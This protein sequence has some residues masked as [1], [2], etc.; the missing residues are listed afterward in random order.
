MF[1]DE[2]DGHHHHRHA[3]LAGAFQLLLGGRADPF[4]RADAALV[5]H[6]PVHIGDAERA[7]HGP[8]RLLHMLGIGIALVHHP[9]RQAM[10][11]KQD[12]RRPLFRRLLKA[13]AHQIGDGRNHPRLVRIA[14]DGFGGHRPAGGQLAPFPHARSAGGGGKLRIKRQQDHPLGP[15]RLGRR[16]RFRGEGMPVAHG[17]EHAIALAQRRFQRLGLLV[18]FLDQRRFAAQLGIDL[19]RHR[20]ALLRDE[21]GQHVADQPRRADDGRIVEQVEQKRLDRVQRIGAAQVEQDDC[22]LSHFD[23]P[24]ARNPAPM[25]PPRPV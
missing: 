23:P 12:A 11:G 20:P 18:G 9:L 21:P 15:P 13:G 6:H 8:R 24:G 5:A 4:H 16:Q 10:G 19:A 3:I 17:D 1:R 2:G 7:D 22:R 25:V 14:A